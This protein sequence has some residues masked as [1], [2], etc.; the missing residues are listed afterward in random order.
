MSKVMDGIAP[1]TIVLLLLRSLLIAVD[2]YGCNNAQPA[3]GGYQQQRQQSS[4]SYHH[5]SSSSSV[6]TVHKKS[7]SQP[8]VTESFSVPIVRQT[9]TP[10]V[11]S[12]YDSGCGENP[13]GGGSKIVKVIRKTTTITDDGCGS[14]YGSGCDVVPTYSSGQSSGYHQYT[15][16]T[17]P[18]PVVIK[19]I[20]RIIQQPKVV[21]V[22][23]VVDGGDV[24]RNECGDNYC[25]QSNYPIVSNGDNYH[26]S[27]SS[28]N[29]GSYAFASASASSSGSV[30]GR[31]GYRQS[32]G[33]HEDQCQ[34]DCW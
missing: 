23:K 4:N 15:T 16:Y 1:A 19:K 13:C 26:S 3:S 5:Q 21:K 6:T 20:T 30:G 27:G 25:G 12:Y 14:G 7:Y 2:G 22:I 33:Y 8:I 28:G 10:Q 34:V 31:S 11:N 9:Y 32:G 18:E 29:G 17:Q 24:V